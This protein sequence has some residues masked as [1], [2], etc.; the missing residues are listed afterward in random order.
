M[1]LLKVFIVSLAAILFVTQAEAQNQTP[2][3][4]IATCF[5]AAK[6]PNYDEIKKCVSMRIS[7][8]VDIAKTQIENPQRKLQKRIALMALQMITYEISDI[9]YSD[10]EKTAKVFINALLIDQNCT[11]EVE[12][13]I[14]NG[15][16]K[17]NDVPNHNEI[18]EQLDFL[19]GFVK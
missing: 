18:I 8:Y 16:W 2:E 12:L 5:E 3:E 9:Q 13:I 11:P 19:S 1:K 7:P 4:V 6:K 14:E 17:I 10:D 15:E